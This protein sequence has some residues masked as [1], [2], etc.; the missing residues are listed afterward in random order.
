MVIPARNEEATIGVLVDRI[1][2]IFHETVEIIVVN[3]HS[4]DHTV[5]VATK[6][7]A[8]VMHNH[9]HPGY[10]HTAR[11]GMFAATGTYVTVMV[12]DLSDDPADLLAMYARRGYDHAVFGDRF[13]SG[14]SNTGY[15]MMKKLV[16]R[17]GNSAAA[18]LSG[19]RY[20]DLT[21]PFKLYHRGHLLSFLE[22]SDAED[23]S[24]GFEIALRY[25]LAGG[26][27]EVVPHHWV[28]RELGTSKFRIKHVIGYSR[29]L[30][31]V[32]LQRAASRGSVFGN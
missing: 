29:T 9:F 31:R 18:W 4:T 27:F 7:G 16:N 23:F 14:G 13:A 32:L 2:D 30:A 21:N 26:R 5:D 17:I 3:D 1:R 15:P 22:A 20:R 12:A 6:H 28:E 10:G 25:V 19:T 11:V 24:L 8:R